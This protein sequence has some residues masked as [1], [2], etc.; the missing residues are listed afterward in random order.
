MKSNMIITD[1]ERREKGKKGSWKILTKVHWKKRASSFWLF[2]SK[3]KAGQI[4][5]PCETE[6]IRKPLNIRTGFY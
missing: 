1:S 6:S 5:Y 3:S 4:K 2:L